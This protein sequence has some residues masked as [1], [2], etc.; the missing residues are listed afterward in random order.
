MKISTTGK[1]SDGARQRAL[2]ELAP[3]SERRA[4]EGAARRARCMAAHPSA[5]ARA[6]EVREVR[7]GARSWA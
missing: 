6:P 7:A 4:R 1:G 2:V 5:S 3:I